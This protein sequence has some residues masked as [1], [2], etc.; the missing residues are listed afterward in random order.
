MFRSL[1]RMRGQYLSAKPVARRV[2]DRESPSE[3]LE[4]RRALPVDAHTDPVSAA[5][6]RPPLFW[7]SRPGADDDVQTRAEKAAFFASSG[8]RERSRAKPAVTSPRGED[9][10]LPPVDEPAFPPL[11]RTG[12]RPRLPRDGG[13]EPPITRGFVAKALDVDV[14]TV[15]RLE[16]NGDLHPRV[17][18]GGI[19]YFE[20]HEVLTLKERRRRAARGR[21]IEVRVVALEM[22]RNGADWRD[23]AIKLRQDPY[24][25]YRLWK[26]FSQEQREQSDDGGPR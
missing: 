10:S 8:Y 18:A 15:R 2:L 14:S 24:E 25:V 1:F 23:V 13:R 26:L 12:G 9:K 22:F 19:R 17:G 6:S 4:D 11:L 5:P 16:A 3:K 7:V 20:M 21:T